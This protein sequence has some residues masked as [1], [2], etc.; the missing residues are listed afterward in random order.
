MHNDTMAGKRLQNSIGRLEKALIAIKSNK[1]TGGKT[2]RTMKKMLA[3]AV[4]LTMAL[5]MN[6]AVF[7]Q[8][9]VTPG[10]KKAVITKEYETT[11]GVAATVTP[12]EALAFTVTPDEE[13]NPYDATIT[14]SKA[15]DSNQ[16]TVDYT[17]LESA[18]VGIY[19]YTVTENDAGTQGVQYDEKTYTI[20][21]MVSWTDDSHK[22]KQVTSEI[23]DEDGLK[24]GGNDGAIVNTF[25]YGSLKVRKTITG[26]LSEKTDTFKVTV[27][28]SATDTVRNDITYTGNNNNNGTINKGWTGTKTVELTVTDGTEVTFNGIP[29]G[30][31]YTVVEDDYTG[32]VN[33]DGKGYTTSYTGTDNE[34]NGNG[35]ILADDTDMVAITNI[36]GTSIDT[37]I[38]TDSLPYLLIAA[39]VVAGGAVLVTRRRRFDD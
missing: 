20:N 28:F 22:S 33:T 15:A 24:Y 32:D 37:G 16:I 11:K 25:D 7:A 39:G 19:T 30:V 2:M 12:S 38:T 13:K 4:A 3:G 5:T 21:A 17:A 14:V 29:A 27:T 10:S 6:V 31:T 26:N 9:E 8:S 35:T 18:P 34:Q 36:K 23:E 1:T